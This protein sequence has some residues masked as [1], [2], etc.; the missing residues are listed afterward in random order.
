MF[1]VPEKYRVTGG[2][3]GS[4]SSYGCA[5]AFVIPNPF[6]KNGKPRLAVICSDNFG[7]EHVSVSIDGRVPTW[8]EMCFIKDTFWDDEDTVIQFHPPKSKYINNCKWCL[9]LWRNSHKKIELPDLLLVGF[10]E[11]NGKIKIP[12][13]MDKAVLKYLGSFT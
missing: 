13:N 8:A 9:H 5:G 11:V 12:E 2:A 1:K 6:T 7:W 10:K 4:N 3:M